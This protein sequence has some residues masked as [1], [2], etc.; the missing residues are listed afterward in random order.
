MK[1]RE[2]E[3][4]QHDVSNEETIKSLANFLAYGW[5]ILNVSASGGIFVYI[6]QRPNDHQTPQ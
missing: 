6:L 2:I 1:K 3:I 4:I 5:D